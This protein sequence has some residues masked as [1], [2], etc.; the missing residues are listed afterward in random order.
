MN[1][2]KYF[3]K[4][5]KGYEQNKKW[6][7]QGVASGTLEDS[8]GQR[9]SVDVLTD[10]VREI[11]SKG[12][13]LTN[14][15]P[16]GG[17]VGGELGDVIDAEIEMDGNGNYE[18]IIT[19]ELDKD[20]PYN[21]YMLKK[22]EKGKKYAFSIEGGNPKARTVFSERLKKYIPEFIKVI[23]T[24]I[25]V[26]TEPSYTPSFLQVLSKAY[27]KELKQVVA[28]DAM[29]ST[30]DDNL[31]ALQQL[32]ITKSKSM[33]KPKKEEIVEE[34]EAVKEAVVEAGVEV[35]AEII[36]EEKKEEVVE[37]QEEVKVVTEPE[38][39]APE[40]EP[41]VIPSPV[42]EK[43]EKSASVV[44]EVEKAEVAHEV[45]KPVEVMQKVVETLTSLGERIKE[46]EAQV[47]VVNGKIEKSA[48][49]DEAYNQIFE[50]L[51]GK[52]DYLESLPLQKK[53]KVLSKSTENVTTKVASTEDVIKA[54]IGA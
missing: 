16:K 40:T 43:L 41:E 11:K 17:P 10:F 20:N 51:G 7:V 49:Q 1:Q 33:A 3:V 12:L 38:A 36:V 47:G 42:E 54:L 19:A 26:T 45:S 27:D 31:N 13:P 35:A 44:Q 34:V 46:L 5:T 52:I 9:L 32:I 23:P 21:A 24:A 22:I 48:N 14:A 29:W 50:K 18:M 8:D 39:E 30:I 15:H 28:E 37:V 4:I 2:N 6:L 25:S 53:S